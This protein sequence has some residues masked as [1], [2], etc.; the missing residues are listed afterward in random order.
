MP[1]GRGRRTLA[2]VTLVGGV[3]LVAASCSSGP[4]TL[5]SS[6]PTT[7]GKQTVPRTSGKHTART[8]AGGHALSPATP[9]TLPG[10]PPNVPD[11]TTVGP[12]GTLTGGAARVPA[13]TGRTVAVPASI[14]ADCSAD[15]STKL[16][17]FFNNLGANSIVLVGAQACYQVTKGVTLRNP[18][19]LTVDGGTFTDD[20]VLP[21]DPNAKPS[22]TAAFTV[23]GGS[24]VTLE[25]MKI[26]GKNPGGYHPPLAFAGAIDVEGTKSAAIKGV[27]ITDPY[28]D[29]I[30][31]SP[32]R[33]G[34]DHASSQ[35]VSPAT[36]VT[37]AG[38]TITGAGRQAVTL[39]S[40]AGAQISNLIVENPGFDAFDL[41]ADQWDEGATNVTIDGCSASGGALFFANGGAGT[42][43]YTHDITVTHCA[44]DKQTAGDPVLVHDIG[45]NKD[46][47]RGPINFVA[48][49]IECGHTAS[50]ACVELS[51]ASVTIENSVLDFPSGTTPE[52]VYHV[53]RR[54]S[55]VFT[56][57][58]VHGFGRTGRLARNSALQVT[59]GHWVSVSGA[60]GSEPVNGSSAQGTG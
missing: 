37:I 29:G 53:A 15:V 43:S 19:G 52:A 49:K 48:D 5:S 1:A 24:D 39:A 26:T 17:H 56:N 46:H 14:P 38:V 40:V 7:S 47:P 22:G 11:A 9:P 55:V 28:G 23:Q 42:G 57:D 32:L 2:L 27:T 16:K 30:S 13:P 45:R 50:L 31:L 34:G 59:G 18:K 20:S 60:V 58:A 51:G 54:S 41:E 35:I 33:G 36:D 3:G 4:S 6:P 25:N 10:A 44:T 8:S 21:S 12:V